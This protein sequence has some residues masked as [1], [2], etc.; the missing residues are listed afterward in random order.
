MIHPRFGKLPELMSTRP[1]QKWLLIPTSDGFVEIT[2][3]LNGKVL[4]VFHENL[5]E[6]AEIVQFTRNGKPNRHAFH[7]VGLAS[8]ALVAQATSSSLDVHQMAGIVP[9]CFREKLGIPPDWEPVAALA[10]GYPG[11]PSKLPEDLREREQAPRVRKP[12][13]EFVFTDKWGNA[14]P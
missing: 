2:S 4:D 5:A 7:D 1:N 10:I 13:S 14:L 3:V 12:Q 11:D 8:A 9:E 6:N